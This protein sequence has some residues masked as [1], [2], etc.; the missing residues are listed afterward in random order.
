[1]KYFCYENLDN[2]RL[3]SNSVD[4]AIIKLLDFK[5]IYN[6]FDYNINKHIFFCY[7]ESDIEL[8]LLSQELINLINIKEV[9]KDNLIKSIASYG[10]H[11]A[12]EDDGGLIQIILQNEYDQLF[13][14]QKVRESDVWDDKLCKWKPF[15]DAKW[16][17]T[18]GVWKYIPDYL[19]NLDYVIL[20]NNIYEKKIHPNRMLR[21]FY[22]WSITDDNSS[23]IFHDACSVKDYSIINLEAVT[24]GTK[25][26]QN[27]IIDNNNKYKK[28][29]NHVK[30]IDIEPISCITYQE[31]AEEDKDTFREISKIHPQ[32]SARTIQELFRLII[33]WAYAYRAFENNE[34]AALLCDKI[35]RSLQMP[36]EVRNELLDEIPPQYVARF[37]LNDELAIYERE[38]DPELPEKFKEWIST[39]Y[40]NFYPRISDYYL[41]IDIEN[42]P[43]DYPM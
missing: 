43:Q 3:I 27:L 36:I 13:R 16:D 21:A 5:N 19:N 28:I 7:S 9:S 33:E 2:T 1:M 41:N 31:F 10:T 23:S 4:S 37:I 11:M 39:V 25:N 8:D 14:P 30:I 34:P 22:I 12:V 20:S 29:L 26:A 18:L 35:L 24:H 6:V 32:C 38:V 40:F 42:L 15:V 17:E